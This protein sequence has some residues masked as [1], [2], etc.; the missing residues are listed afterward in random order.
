ME[1]FF[2]EIDG[3]STVGGDDQGN[4][5]SIDGLAPELSNVT[6]NGQSFGEGRGSGGFGA[7]DLPPEMIRR[8][9]VFK[10]PT[11]TL[12]E[13]GAGGSVN[14]QLRNPVDITQATGSFKGRLSYVPD[15][16]SFSPSASFFTGRPSESRKF[17]YMLSLTLSERVREYNSQDIND[18]ILEDFGGTSA[19][20]PS[21]VRNNAVKDTQDSAFAGLTVGYRPNPTLDIGA[22]VFVSQK[23]R[24]VATHALQHRFE[25]QRDLD[26]LAFDERIVS[27]M[28]S[29]DKSREN[30]RVVGSSRKD[31]TD[32]LILGL[33]FNWRRA[34]WRIDGALSYKADD[35]GNDAPT[36]SATFSAN[37][38]FD[39]R[40]GHDG[41]LP[42][43][44]PGEFPAIGNFA[45]G[46][47]NLSE[48]QTEDTSG[49]AALDVSRNLRGGFFRRI[50][51][52]VKARDMDRT[53][54]SSKG[55]VQLGDDL[56]LDDFFNGGYRHTPW[57]SVSWPVSNLGAINSV[58][59]DADVDWQ[60]NLLNEYDMERRTLAG[61]FQ[62]EFRSN[63]VNNRFVVGNVGVRVVG[64]ET[65]IAGF[66]E[67]G[68][69][70]EPVAIKNTY[71]DVLPS[72]GARMRVAERTVLSVGAAKVMT[73]P[74]FN[75]LA[76]GVR[77]NYADKTG[78]S[79]NPYLE[80]FRADEYMAELTWAPVRG[81]RFTGNLTYRDVESYFALGEASV[82]IADDVFLVT[83]P[84]NGGD[85]RILTATIKLEQNLRRISR[86]LQN[87]TLSLSYTHNDSSADMRDPYTSKKLPLPNT[88]E[89]VARVNLDYSKEKFSGRL[90]Y[91]WRG[92]SLKA[93][94]SESGLSVWN[95]GAGS[96]NLNMG[97]RLND[98]F[99]FSLDARNLLE[100]M[101]LR[102]TDL[103]TQLWRITERDR[104]IS[105]TLRGR[106]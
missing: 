78:R 45:A 37:N 106:W 66:Q 19:Y 89:Q 96:L 105:A 69:E 92:R 24:D 26:A 49:V 83:R 57:D 99:Q 36:Q 27:E 23:L 80:P 30:L 100:E 54:T 72:F 41:S 22:S 70:P 103:D 93:S 77:V 39:Y 97:W 51:F 60:E 55:E 84:I 17:G 81:R 61:Y 101:Q 53:R 47:I 31:Q 68:G 48:R 44:Y 52:G 28:E 95:Q 40:A 35:N 34:R 85:G 18:W 65:D 87:M 38:P 88:A 16:N 11:A 98:V 15:K 62:A 12:E 29:N 7:G 14:L 9:E 73:H 5:F 50:R 46:R 86:W 20:Y 43:S 4:A 58:V 91:Q 67:A 75:D 2:D 42:T 1:D 79:G 94:I 104:S 6:L 21:Q 8:V 25:K 64:T 56:G 59:Q 76:P 74:A 82:D 90:S 10:I 102:T 33:N 63:Q 32:S 71:T 13:G 3:L